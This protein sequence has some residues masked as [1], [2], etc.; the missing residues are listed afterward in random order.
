MSVRAGFSRFVGLLIFTCLLVA[1]CA[2]TPASFHSVALTPKTA[3]TIGE[4]QTLAIAAQVTNDTSN[5]GVTWALTPASG[6]GALSGT[7]STAATYNAPASVSSAT[8]VT[9]TATS[10]TF[11]NESATLTITV[12]PHPSIVT[13]SL[14]SGSINN[15]Y[16]AT[17]TASGGVSPFS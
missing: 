12:E 1:G 2:G 4:G 11:P 6:A 14:P 13:T 8:T 15:A 16:S 10:V 17:V 3:Q 5:A 7:S 9:V